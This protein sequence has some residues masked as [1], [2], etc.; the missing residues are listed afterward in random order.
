MIITWL[1]MAS[2]SVWPAI[3]FHAMHNYFDQVVFQSL[4][5][6]EKSVY[7]VGEIGVIT[8]AV[9]ALIAA[10]ILVRG[11]SVFSGVKAFVSSSR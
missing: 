7:F 6:S 2:N 9:T 11:R 3:L 10:L 5:N 1:R 4:T 8:L